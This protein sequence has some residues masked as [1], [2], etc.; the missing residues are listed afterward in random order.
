MKF[1][2]QV[3]RTDIVGNSLLLKCVINHIAWSLLLPH[4][5]CIYEL[6]SQSSKP[7][8][9][10][11]F[12]HLQSAHFAEHHMTK[13]LLFFQKW[14]HVLFSL[15]KL[16]FC[17]W[18]ACPLVLIYNDII[19]FHI[20]CSFLLPCRRNR[21]MMLLTLWCNT[22]KIGRYFSFASCTRDQDVPGPFP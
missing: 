5:L 12:W 17:T 22:P 14:R 21:N 18:E 4:T 8:L 15:W 7:Q 13:L 11:D 3:T 9:A 6:S 20:S 2:R 16:G 10:L 1:K 19:F